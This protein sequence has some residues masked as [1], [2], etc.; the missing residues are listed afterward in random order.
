[1]KKIQNKLIFNQYLE[2][3]GGG[4]GGGGGGRWHCQASIIGSWLHR[5]VFRVTATHLNKQYIVNHTNY[6]ISMLRYT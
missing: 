4:G 1:M 5:S 3:G 6:D 2:E